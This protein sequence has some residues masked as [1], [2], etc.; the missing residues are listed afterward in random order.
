M[1]MFNILTQ[2]DE[3]FT[4]KTL[5]LAVDSA[6]LPLIV[7]FQQINPAWNDYKRCKHR[8]INDTRMEPAEEAG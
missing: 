5:D 4:K 2:A 1:T 8:Q 6:N 3:S 7:W